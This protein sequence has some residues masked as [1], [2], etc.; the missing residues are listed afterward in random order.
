MQYHPV[1]RRILH[2]EQRAADLMA[3]LTLLQ[4][5]GAPDQL[6]QVRRDLDCVLLELRDAHGQRAHALERLGMPPVLGWA[7]RNQG[8]TVGAGHP[9]TIH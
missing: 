8:Y 7:S 4:P 6:A 5:A 9:A 1:S 3:R 2:L